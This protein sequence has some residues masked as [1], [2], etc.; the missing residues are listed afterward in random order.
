MG[1]RRRIA[2]ALGAGTALWLVPAAH[3]ATICV[4]DPGC[5]GDQAATVAAGVALAANGAHP[6]RD[7]VKLGPQAFTE[8]ALLVAAGNAI[9]LV[10]DGTGRTELRRPAGNSV[11]T[12]I[13]N[14]PTAVVSDLDVRLAAGSGN[15]GLELYSATRNVRVLA[16]SAPG[17]TGVTFMASPPAGG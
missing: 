12:L 4:Q 16:D 15:T 2:I 5:S 8:S 6:G 9:D 10:G 17:G 1:C 14:E 7:R 13:V 11:T 3:A